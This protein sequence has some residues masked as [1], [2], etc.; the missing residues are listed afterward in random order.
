MSSTLKNHIWT[1]PEQVFARSITLGDAELP[2]GWTKNSVVIQPGTKAC[3][4]VDGTFIGDIPPGEFTFHDLREKLLSWRKGEATLLLTR[5]D[6]VRLPVD[7]KGI[8]SADD[9]PMDIRVD[10]GVQID[11]PAVFVNNMMGPRKDFT[12]EELAARL[13]PAVR[14]EAWSA[15]ARMNVDDLRG[16]AIVSKVAQQIVAGIADSFKRYGLRVFS[17]EG[18]L[19]QPTGMEKHWD[20]VKENNIEIAG[21]QLINKRLG[22]DVSIKNERGLL[23]SQL[24]GIE[25][26]NELEALNAEVTRRSER[27]PALEKLRDAAIADTF[28]SAK[29]SEELKQLLSGVDK[30]RL[31]RKEEIG[32]LVE[33]FEERKTDRASLREHIVTVLDLNRQ[34]EVDSLKLAVEHSLE[35]ANTKNELEMAEA[36]NSVENVKWRNE[37]AREFES[38]ERHREERKKE[39]TSKWDR[40]RETQRQK[41]DSSWEKLLHEQREETIRTELAYKEAERKRRLELLEA[42]NVAQIE[43]QKIAGERLRREFE[44]EMDNRESDTQFDRLKR[45]QDMNFEGHSRQAQLDADLTAQAESRANA[46]EIDKLKT[47]GDL[48]A[49][50]LIAA[51]NSDN[52]QV[53]ADL[54]M[55]EVKSGTDIAAASSTDQAKLNEERLKMYERLNEAEKSKSDAISDVFQQALKG[56]QTAVDQMISGL[57]NAS[58]PRSPAQP[59][60]R[61][62]APVTSVAEWHVL[63]TG[64]NQS[65]PHS[66]QQ[67]QSMAQQGQVVAETLVWKAGMAGWV[68]I[69]KVTELA[70]V[71][72]A[73][74]PPPPP[75]SAAPPPPP[76]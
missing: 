19:M 7:C 68:A 65:G 2:R 22:Q 51:S 74:A 20:K 1:T 17:V 12:V 71:L 41:Q 23:E 3:A 43:K 75:T 31:L 46:H 48:S 67:I 30:Q 63:L 9:V 38:A 42:E 24:H 14:Q 8:V 76:A 61:P 21:E 10:V 47:M 59:A 34:Q 49:E 40:I 45:V 25:N 73:A 32:Q 52:A 4:V 29:S 69:T 11:N 6:V 56:Q 57:A 54:K 39:L 27:I 60:V 5:S 55:Q 15:T 18:L 37:I 72:P 62:P 36:T 35:L 64:N 28:D 50:A 26:R 53:L 58:R 33:G 44:L 16:A 70:A 13:M 66:P